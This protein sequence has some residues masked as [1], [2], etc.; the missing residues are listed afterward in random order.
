MKYVIFVQRNQSPKSYAI[1]FEYLDC[2]FL[3][4][5]LKHKIRVPLIALA[6]GL[7]Q[8]NHDGRSVTVWAVK[9]EELVD[10]LVSNLIVVFL[11]V[12]AK[13]GG[14]HLSF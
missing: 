6:N 13:E 3:S 7:I 2:E 14:V 4:T 1:A 10:V 5:R 8:R 12:H 9:Q 11:A